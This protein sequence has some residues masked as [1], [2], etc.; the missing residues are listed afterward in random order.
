MTEPAAAVQSGIV[1]NSFFPPSN[2][3]LLTRKP[4][5]P[6]DI[7]VSE[8]TT[9]VTAAK[10]TVSHSNSF[11][12][13]QTKDG[14][15][16][17]PQQSVEQ[18]NHPSDLHHYLLE[19]VAIIDMSPKQFSDHHVTN[20]YNATADLPNSEVTAESVYYSNDISDQSSFDKEMEEFDQLCEEIDVHFTNDEVTADILSCPI[21]GLQLKRG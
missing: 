17:F 2:L 6:L 14:H 20:D 13:H 21:C 5:L 16:S 18:D 12:T 1:S 4:L 11:L 15:Q 19:D 9:D 3:K 7:T 8:S 10:T